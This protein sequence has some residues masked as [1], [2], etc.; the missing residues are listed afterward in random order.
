[1]NVSELGLL[2]QKTVKTCFLENIRHSEIKKQHIKQTPR[3]NLCIIGARK[4]A[5]QGKEMF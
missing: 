5:I 3:L 1:M 4:N 2:P